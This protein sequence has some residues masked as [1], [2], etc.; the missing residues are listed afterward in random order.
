M[1]VDS[2]R[3]HS[4][5]RARGLELC[6]PNDA[7]EMSGKDPPLPLSTGGLS[8]P[9]TQWL[10]YLNEESRKQNYTV[11]F[12]IYCLFSPAIGF[13]KCF[14]GMK[15]WTAL[16]YGLKEWQ[17]RWRGIGTHR[18][19]DSSLLGCPPFSPPRIF[20][21]C[22]LQQ[23]LRSPQKPRLT[24]TDEDIIISPLSLLAVEAKLEFFHEEFLLWVPG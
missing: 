3:P 13:M 10:L 2:G 4:N 11:V 19:S 5:L 15:L 22:P 16:G 23:A 12:R 7:S 9:Y 21:L 6:T 18:V 1:V 8:P 20:F 17:P 14:E 24:L